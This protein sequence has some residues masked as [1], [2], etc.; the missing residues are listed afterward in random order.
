MMS[1]PPKNNNGRVQDGSAAV[2]TGN[3]LARVMILLG[4][5]S[6]WINFRYYN[7]LPET[8]YYSSSSEDETLELLEAESTEGGKPKKVKKTFD[9]AFSGGQLIKKVLINLDVV[10]I[11][12]SQTLLIWFFNFRTV[13]NVE[14]L[15]L[16]AW[17]RN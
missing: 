7:R 13:M 12:P 2:V 15:E 3:G 17:N 8:E 4:L 10:T 14:K 9:G 11:T 1:R 6:L 16:S 5:V